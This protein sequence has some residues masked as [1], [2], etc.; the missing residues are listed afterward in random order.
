MDS[1]KGNNFFCCL[2]IFIS[3]SDDKKEI[4]KPEYFK[5]YSYQLGLF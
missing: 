1:D 5:A 4:I 3:R 2:I